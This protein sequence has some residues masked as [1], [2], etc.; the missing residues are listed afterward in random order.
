MY[1]YAQDVQQTADGGYVV[2][3]YAYSND[4]DVSGNHG[5]WDYWVVKLNESGNLVWQKCL[6]GRQD[7]YAQD[8]QQTTDG[9]YVVAG[10]TYSNDYNVSGNHGDW[11]YWVV[12]LNESGNLV[13][14]RCLGGSNKEEACSIQ[15]TSDGGYVVAGSTWSVDGNVRGNHGDFDYWIVKLGEINCT[16]TAPD[17]VCSGSTGNVASTAE[18]G[19]SYAWSITNGAITS[20]SYAQSISFTAGSSGPIR[21][22]V[23]VTKGDYAEECHK[24]IAIKAT[25]DSSLTSDLAAGDSP[26]PQSSGMEYQKRDGGDGQAGTPVNKV[27][28]YPG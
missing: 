24:D 10:S 13:W 28:I 1:D 19:A 26:D 7:E 3:G 14:Q 22:A 17:A 27:R 4:G 2:A 18:S 6:G 23:R 8:V 20:S 21:L 5:D 12:K 9:G 15:Q 16:I 25:P 11:D